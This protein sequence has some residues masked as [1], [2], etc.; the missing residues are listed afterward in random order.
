VVDR[1][2]HRRLLHGLTGLVAGDRQAA[3]LVNDI[4]EL[5][6]KLSAQLNRSLSLR[7]A[8]H[9]WLDQLYRPTVQRLREALGRA[10]TTA[11]ST[12]RSS[13]TSGTRASGREKTSG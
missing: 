13:S 3:L 10:T 1:D 12:A 8:A 5:Q 11:S 4:K 2:Y 6:A 7:V 9:R